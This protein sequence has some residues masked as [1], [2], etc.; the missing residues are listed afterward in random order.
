[1]R[2]DSI[3]QKKGLGQWSVPQAQALTVP[4]YALGAISYLA[5]AWV[6]DRQQLR[7]LYEVIFLGVCVV[8]Y[9]LSMADSSPAVSYFATFVIATGL[10]VAVGLPLAWLPSNNPR[11][12]KRTTASGIQMTICNCS[13]ILA[14][15]VSDF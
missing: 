13:G 15:F 8:G 3:L 12:G 14:P 11:Y 2:T 7:G 9:G 5:V 4:C 6:S 1:M 10:F